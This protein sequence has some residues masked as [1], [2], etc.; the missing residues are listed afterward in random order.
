MSISIII[1]CFNSE[2]YIL[3]NVAKLRSY[4]NKINYRYEVILIDDCSSDKT[5]EVEYNHEQ[6]RFTKKQKNANFLNKFIKYL[7]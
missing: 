2:K 4:I 3:K 1:P 5:Y 7:S 6:K